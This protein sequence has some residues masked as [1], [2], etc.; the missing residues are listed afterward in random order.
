MKGRLMAQCAPATGK[1][2]RDL[3][4]A[5]KNIYEFATVLFILSGIPQ[6]DTFASFLVPP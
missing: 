6:S 1:S 5:L 3:T 4:C 2:E